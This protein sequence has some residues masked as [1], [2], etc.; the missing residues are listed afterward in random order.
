[1]RLE[2]SK[3]SY[4]GPVRNDKPRRSLRVQKNGVAR[5][6]SYKMKSAVV[7]A[8]AFCRSA[9]AAEGRCQP[10]VQQY[11]R[12]NQSMHIDVEYI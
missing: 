11:G 1:M 9:F 12:I 10:S 8:I 4:S 7:C 5:G 6:R 3:L 2:S